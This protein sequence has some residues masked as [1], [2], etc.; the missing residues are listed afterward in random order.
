M[1]DRADQKPG[2]DV[3]QRFDDLEAGLSGII[4]EL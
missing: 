4:A 3:Y 2:R 1:L